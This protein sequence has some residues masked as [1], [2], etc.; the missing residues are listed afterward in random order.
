MCSFYHGTWRDQKPLYTIEICVIYTLC[1][2]GTKGC[3]FSE[4]RSITLIREGIQCV[5]MWV[6]VFVLGME[7]D[8][9]YCSHLR[10]AIYL[11]VTPH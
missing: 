3:N 2:S 8:P 10:R 11:S 9:N 5:C 1:W 4:C 7:L 6:C